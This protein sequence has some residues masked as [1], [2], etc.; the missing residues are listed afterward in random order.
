MGDFPYNQYEDSGQ[1]FGKGD[2]IKQTP[3]KSIKGSYTLSSI[4]SIDR[5]SSP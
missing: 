5:F 3:T 1:S 2:V 4:Y